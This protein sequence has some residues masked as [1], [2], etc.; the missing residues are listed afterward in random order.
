MRRLFLKLLRRGRLQRDLERELAF[1]ADMSRQNQNPITLGNL[2][3]IKE[4]AF[5]LWRFNLLENLWRDLIYACRGLRRSPA[6]VTSALLSLGLG[7]GANTAI[8]QLLDAV[9]LRSLPVQKPQE[10]AGVRIVGGHGGMGVNPGEYPE[11]TRPI[12]DADLA[13]LIPL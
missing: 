11:L 3:V 5:D 7:I 6:L 10:L 4:L 2:S 12:W 13:N 8:F 1:H 9:R